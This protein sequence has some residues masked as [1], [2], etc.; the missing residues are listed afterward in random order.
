VF[1]L[2]YTDILSFVGLELILKFK[3]WLP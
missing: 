2:F 3:P 1:V